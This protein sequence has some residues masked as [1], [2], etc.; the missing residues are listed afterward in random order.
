MWQLMLFFFFTRFAR[1]KGGDVVRF[2]SLPEIEHPFLYKHERSE[3]ESTICTYLGQIRFSI[4]C[5]RFARTNM[6]HHE[7]FNKIKQPETAQLYLILT[8]SRYARKA[9][10]ESFFWTLFIFC[11]K[12]A[13]NEQRP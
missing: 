10:L 3:C 9:C 8:V 5:A 1:K 12:S 2:W 4:L 11:A 13:K 6:R 7:L